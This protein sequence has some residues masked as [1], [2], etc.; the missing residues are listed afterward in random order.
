MV[1][2]ELSAAW[3]EMW[4]SDED[5]TTKRMRVYS[6][7]IGL[8]PNISCIKMNPPPAVPPGMTC[9]EGS[10]DG[11][12]GEEDDDDDEDNRGGDDD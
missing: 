3:V 1:S 6:W 8:P 10:Q 11:D 4:T 9:D 2:P 12:S 7:G 5:K